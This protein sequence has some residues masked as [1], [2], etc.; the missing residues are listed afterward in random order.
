M[1]KTIYFKGKPI[2]LAG[3]N[4][5]TGENAPD[6]RV[7]SADLKE[8]T[9]SDFN[10]SFKLITTFPS[11]DTPVCDLQVK[12]FN[13]KS[14]EFS[15]ELVVIGV[16]KDLPFAQK[17]FCNNN[18]IKGILLFSDYKYS[19]FGINYGLLIKEL[20]RDNYFGQERYSALYTGCRRVKRRSGLYRCLRELGKSAKNP[21]DD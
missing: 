15:P 1:S 18:D 16:S 12:E 3:R 21:L 11:L 17:R 13:R 10:S 20:N 8:F 19:S 6:F 9:L 2:T 5:K 14:T 7:V 4:L